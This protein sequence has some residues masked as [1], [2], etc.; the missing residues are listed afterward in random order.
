MLSPSSESNNKPNDFHR[1][2]AGFSLGLYFD[3]EDGGDMFPWNVGLL[4]TDYKRYIPEDST[5]QN[6]INQTKTNKPVQNIWPDSSK[7]K[8]TDSKHKPK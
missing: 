7:N 2:H 1:L 4:L 8:L 6:K 3:S 5:L